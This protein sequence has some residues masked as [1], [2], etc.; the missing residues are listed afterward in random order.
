MPSKVLPRIFDAVSEALYSEKKLR[1]EYTNMNGKTTSAVV[2]P[3]ALVQQDVRLYLIC[4]FDHFDNVVHLALH[5]FKKQKSPLL[6]LIDPKTLIFSLTSTTAT[7]IT[8]T[9]NGCTGF[10]NSRAMSPQRIWKKRPSTLLKTDSKR[11]RNLALRSRHPR[12]QNAGRLGR[13][14]EERRPDNTQ[15]KRIFRK[16]NGRRRGITKTGEFFSGLKRFSNLLRIANVRYGFIDLAQA[17]QQISINFKELLY[18]ARV[19]NKS[20]MFSIRR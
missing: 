14:V 3:L 16:R 18:A 19:L 1:I 10:L 13:H 15:S 9:E 20:I 2:S 4:Q 11:R 7:L 12:L 17:F 8:A 5:R 6:M